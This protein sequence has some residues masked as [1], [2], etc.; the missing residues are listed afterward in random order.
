MKTGLNRTFSLHFPIRDI[1]V[2]LAVLFIGLLIT[3]ISVSY[4][5][6][7]MKKVAVR[8][9]E[10]TCN[11]LLI[12]I[13]TRLDQQAQLLHSGAAL[14][15]SSD[16]IT[17]TEWHRFY[18]RTRINRYLPGIQGFGFTVLI[19]KDQLKQHIQ[20]IRYEG[21][22]EYDIFPSGEREIYSSIVYIE[23][24]SDRNLNA[25]GYDMYS[26]PI[27]R[28]TMEASRD[29]N[30]AMLSGKVT[31]MQETTEDVQAGVLMYVPVYRNN[32]PTISIE[33]RRT[34]IK[35]WIF[36]PYRMKDLM[37]GIHQ[38]VAFPDE[39]RISFNIYDE[40]GT[41]NDSLLYNS[42][43]NEVIDDIGDLKL[44]LPIE[45]NGKKWILEFISK[46]QEKTLLHRDQTIVL[47]AGLIISVLLFF[48]TLLR[49]NSIVKTR[50]ISKLNMQLEKL[51][52]DK[53]RFITILGHD[54]KSPFTSILGFLE[55]LTEDI[56]KFSIDDIESHVNIINDASKQ[57]Y[58]LLED[59]LVWTKAHSGKIPFNPQILDLHDVYTNV[60]S[61]L[62]PAAD[63]KN[64]TI[65]YSG[66]GEVNIFADIDMLKTILRNLVT[67]AIK[68][69]KPGG[70]I[71][72]NAVKKQGSVIVSVSDNGVGIEADRLPGLFDIS[73]IFS[74]MGTF[75]EKG[76]GLGLIL[77]KEFVEKHDGKIWV[78]SEYGKGSNF[79]FTMPTRS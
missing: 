35:G 64:I 27:R 1:L 13:V 26:E 41:S 59:L 18:D 40:G 15:A 43:G 49:I 66:H 16:T 8:D 4:I 42:A 34:A 31:L 54:L 46:V 52:L 77:C 23:P 25:F 22:S 12:K 6:M 47:I 19:P 28:I 37:S 45:F 62:N 7:N 75:N 73:Q 33:D 32:M 78:E 67:N 53:D 10:Y 17:R 79:R 3:I 20:N 24:F 2:T 74:T 9:F 14:F 58:N 65:N 38:N 57:T 50:Q 48:L 11:E 36:S 76:S 39:N 5:R 63:A 70:S 72:I 51:N 55:L 56:R 68:F 71:N 21:Y 61:V 60:E 44:T 29:S 30:R 69:T